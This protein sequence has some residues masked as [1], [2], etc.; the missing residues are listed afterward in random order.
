MSEDD[1]TAVLLFYVIEY[2]Y[3]WYMHIRLHIY[4]RIRIYW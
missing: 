1:F 2:R 3:I 4:R